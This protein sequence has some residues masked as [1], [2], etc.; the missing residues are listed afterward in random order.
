MKSDRIIRLTHRQSNRAALVRGDHM[1]LPARVRHIRAEALQQRIRR[2][3]EKANA[4]RLQL[5]HESSNFNHHFIPSCAL[6]VTYRNMCKTGQTSFATFP[7]LRA[8]GVCSRI[9]HSVSAC[10]FLRSCLGRIL[11]HFHLAQAHSDGN[12]NCKTGLTFFATFHFF[13][14]GL[15]GTSAVPSKP[16]RR[17]VED[18]GAVSCWTR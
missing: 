6:Y 9:P 8:R 18:V 14:Y 11:Y 16:I 15:L 10:A 1:A 2:A 4:R 17:L 7:T 3:G 5:V 12:Q 13:P